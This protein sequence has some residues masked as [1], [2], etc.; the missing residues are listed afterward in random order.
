MERWRQYYEELS[1]HIQEED[2]AKDEQEENEPQTTEEKITELS[3]KLKSR[4]DEIIMEMV[5]YMGRNENEKFRT[6]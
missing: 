4:K 5:N 6:Y 2:T 3:N 1:E